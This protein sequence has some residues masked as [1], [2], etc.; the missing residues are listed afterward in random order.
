MSERM[1]RVPSK[2]RANYRD[3]QVLRGRMPGAT[4]IA[5]LAFK[6]AT[7]DRSVTPPGAF[8]MTGSPGVQFR[9]L[10][11]RGLQ[12]GHPERSE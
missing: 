7:L 1:R 5:G 11:G 4:Q 2:Q 9:L 8:S 6:A 3:L 10:G 12:A